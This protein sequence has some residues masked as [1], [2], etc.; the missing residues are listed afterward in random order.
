MKRQLLQNTK[1]LPYTQGSAVNRAG[2]QSGILAVVTGASGDVKLAIEHS[3]TE[4]GSYV[5]VKDNGVFL[6]SN[7]V[8]GLN[9][10][11]LTNL[12]L[13]LSGCKAFIK[14]KVTGT[15]AASATFALAL[16]DS[17]SQPL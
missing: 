13:D 5:E 9:N 8:T 15:A 12:D 11:D 16:G 14:I 1:V 6:D 10:K 3:D 7:E 17:E 2:F 4:A